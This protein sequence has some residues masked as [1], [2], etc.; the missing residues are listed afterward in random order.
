MLRRGT[1]AILLLPSGQ[2][3]VNVPVSGTRI[4]SVGASC[5]VHLIRK[6]IEMRSMIIKFAMAAFIA[7]TASYVGLSVSSAAT[8]GGGPGTGT[9]GMTGMMDGTGGMMGTNKAQ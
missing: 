6:E 7:A 2:L 9:G 4:L 1:S 8:K 3:Q 5:G